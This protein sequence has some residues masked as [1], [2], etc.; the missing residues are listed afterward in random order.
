MQRVMAI[1]VRATAYNPNLLYR[2]PSWNY[3]LFAN[4]AKAIVLKF[5]NFLIL[6]LLLLIQLTRKQEGG[7]AIALN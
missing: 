5:F 6:L 2:V 4:T 7:A 3:Y 1:K